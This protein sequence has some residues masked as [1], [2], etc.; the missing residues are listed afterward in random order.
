M[1]GFNAAGAACSSQVSGPHEL[2]QAPAILHSQLMISPPMLVLEP[3]SSQKP[4][5]NNDFIF[6]QFFD[7]FSMLLHISSNKVFSPSS[8]Q[9]KMPGFHEN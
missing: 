8:D 2:L 5:K 3:L 7:P 9:E 6:K 1:M 4:K